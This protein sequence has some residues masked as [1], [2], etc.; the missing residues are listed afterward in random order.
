MTKKIINI[1]LILVL[2]VTILPIKQVGNAL[3]N[4]QW[5]EEIND[6][7][8]NHADKSVHAKWAYIG[9]DDLLNGNPGFIIKEASRFYSFSQRL[10]VHPCGEIHY[11]PPD[12]LS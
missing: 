12:L 7:S 9:H 6:H 8:E 1:I 4:N 5:T 3:F 11:P 10:P 2:C